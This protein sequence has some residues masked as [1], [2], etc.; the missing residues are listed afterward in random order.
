M[1]LSRVV[2]REF[3]NHFYFSYKQMVYEKVIIEQIPS[4]LKLYSQ[5][6]INLNIYFISFNTKLLNSLSNE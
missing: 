1:V 4:P 5:K 3:K 6:N 2:L